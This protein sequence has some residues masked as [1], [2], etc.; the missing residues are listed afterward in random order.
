[1][2]QPDWIR[3]FHA[4]KQNGTPAARK[5]RFWLLLLLEALLAAAILAA[6]FHARQTAAP[7]AVDLTQWKSD[8]IEYDGRWYVD[9][10]LV[11]TDE[12]IILLD[13]PFASVPAGSYTVN[14][15]YSCNYDQWMSFSA[16]DKADR[17]IRAGQVRLVPGQSFV[18]YEFTLTEDVDQLEI[19]FHY[20][21][22]GSLEISALTLAPNQTPYKSAL[23]VLLIL[24]IG[25]DLAYIWRDAFRRHK[26]TLLL[27]VGIALLPSLPLLVQGIHSGH[28]VAFHLM[29]IEGIAQELQRGVFPVRLS[30]LWMDGYGYPVSIYYG[31]FL[32]YLPALLRLAGIP[33]VASYKWY[34]FCINLLTAVLAYVCFSRMGQKR[35]VALAACAAYVCAPY[36]M[37][38]IYVRGAVG[39][40]SAVTFLPVV[41]LGVYQIYTADLSRRKELC[42]AALILALGMTGVLCTHLLSAEMAAIVIAL[43]CLLLARRTFRLRRILAY[44]LAVGETVLFSLFFLVPFLDYYANVSVRINTT[45]EQST[46]KIQYGG[47]YL[48]QYFSFFQNPIGQS[49]SDVA[50]RMQMTPGLVL[51]AALL[52]A[53]ILW[54]NGKA[55]RRLRLY[56][57]LACLMLWLSS[58]LFPWDFLAAHSRLGNFLAQVQFPWRYLSFAILFLC[59]LLGEALAQLPAWSPAAARALSPAA[60]LAVGA[61]MPLFFLS[62]YCNNASLFLYYDTAELNTYSVSM[63]EYIREGTDEWYL[64]TDIQSTHVETAA[65]LAR[66]GTA[67]D[68]YCVTGDTAGTVE[69]PLFHYKGYCAYDDSGNTYEI[70]DGTNNVVAFQLPAHFDGN[71]HVRFRSPWYWRI[72]EAVSLVSLL[73]LAGV[74]LLGFFRRRVWPARF[75]LTADPAADFSLTS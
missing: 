32:L 73:A 55:S 65:L 45:L 69:L 49:S 15:W 28:D 58:D 34:I 12:S 11:A 17:Y 8:Y 72:S 56:T 42:R 64:S 54:V 67:M 6:F 30:S 10:E 40:Y 9:S 51:M 5:K 53:V 35:W 31:D 48:G 43:V 13:G 3:R 52:L 41:A 25:L 38:N 24:S 66:D 7:I 4:W 36:R 59:L 33:L 23:F 57:V 50:Q 20:S 14:V 46:Q 60:V 18:S 1:M 26:N 75:V 21:G 16:P 22:I 44:L 37:V 27:L 70:F 2:H 39:E 74:P 19:L 68:L 63:G 61:V 47:A 71:I 62:A 29:R